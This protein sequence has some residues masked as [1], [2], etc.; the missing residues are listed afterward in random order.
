MLFPIVYH[1]AANRSEALFNIAVQKIAKPSQENLRAEAG[2]L[3][4][5]SS[6]K[7]KLNFRRSLDIPSVNFND[8]RNSDI[9]GQWYWYCINIILF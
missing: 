2:F 5:C 1:P 7:A 4:S 6:P 9:E 3:W 8:Y